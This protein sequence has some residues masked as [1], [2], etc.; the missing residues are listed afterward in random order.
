MSVNKILLIDFVNKKV[1]GAYQGDNEQTLR[2]L[3][4]LEDLKEGRRKVLESVERIDKLIREI[5]QLKGD[6]KNGD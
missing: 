4:T 5:G 2:S 6:N 3:P 1:I